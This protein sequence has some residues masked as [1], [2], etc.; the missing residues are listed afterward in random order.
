MKLGIM[1][2]YF[3][4][5]IGYWQLLAAVDKY[6]VY[7]DVN[8]ITRGW[9]HRNRILIDGKPH[10]INLPLA[11]ASQN[12]LINQVKVTADE[13]LKDKV[14]K[15]IYMAYHKASRFDMVF[16]VMEH[17]MKNEETNLAGFLL[18]S[19]REICEYLDIGT[20]LILS[21][22]MEKDNRLKG[23]EKILHICKI[24]HADEYYNSIGG[25][26]LYSGKQFANKNIRLAF[27]KPE[28]IKYKQFGD[29]FIE[30][31]SILDVLMFNK[32]EQIKEFLRIYELVEE[33]E[34]F[35]T[36]T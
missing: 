23:E 30:N 24:L 31:L 6:V 34:K 26:K 32:K 14:L 10:Y 36:R 9:I 28:Q 22:D 5:Y 3:L 21:S 2:P 25:T 12:K 20:E 18:N 15:T 8:Y 16:P 19:I 29:P 33:N 27:L 35:G 4:P 7:D 1:Q 13:K 11:G 17:I